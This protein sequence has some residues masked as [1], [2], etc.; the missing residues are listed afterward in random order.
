MKKKI[1]AILLFL[2][3]F[4]VSINNVKADIDITCGSEKCP[5]M[6]FSIVQLTS[7]NTGTSGT[8][9]YHALWNN[10]FISCNNNSISSINRDNKRK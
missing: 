6:D 2:S 1:M 10:S 5:D 3:F 8:Y 7:S 9:K 4:I